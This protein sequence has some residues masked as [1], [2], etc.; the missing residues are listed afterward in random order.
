[1]GGGNKIGK[2]MKQK[3]NAEYQHTRVDNNKQTKPRPVASAAPHTI[4][5]AYVKIKQD[6]WNV[7]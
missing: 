4:T 7:I 3:K 1:M 5:P 2:F 6:L